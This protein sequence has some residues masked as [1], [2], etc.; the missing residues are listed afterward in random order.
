[1]V[2]HDLNGEMDD[3]PSIA[4]DRSAIHFSL[5]GPGTLLAL[6]NGDLSDLTHPKAPDYKVF[7]G[8]ALAIIQSTARAGTIRLHAESAGL[9]GATIEVASRAD[10]PLPR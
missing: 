1:M 10:A 8:K 3:V 4:A 9:K 7:A 6:D 5:E 2:V